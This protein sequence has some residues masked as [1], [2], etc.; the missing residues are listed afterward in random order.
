GGDALAARAGDDFVV[1]AFLGGHGV[2]DGFET[3]ELFFVHVLRGLLEAGEGADRRH[4]L[5]N[6]LHGTHLR[7]L[8][9]LIAEVFEREA[10]AE[11]GFLGELLLLFAVQRRFSLLDE[12]HHVAHAED[13]AYNAIGMEGLEGVGFFTCTDE[14]DGLAGHMPDG[15]RRAA[16]CV[17]VHFCQDNASQSKTRM[18]ILGR[19][20][21]VLAGHGIGDEQNLRR[22]EEFF[23][24]LHLRHE[25]FVDVQA[26]GGIDDKR[27]AA[28]DDGFT[29]GLFGQALD[30]GGVGGFALLVALV[31]FGFNG[32]GDDF[33]LL[34]GGGAIDVHRDQHGTV[35]TLLEPGGELAG[36]S[37][38]AAPLQA[39][40]EN[41]GGRLGG[42]FE[43]GRV[44]AEQ[45]DKLV[46]N[47]FDDLLGGGERGE[48]FGADGLDADLLDVVADDVEVVDGFEQG[49]GDFAE[50]FGDV[51]FSERALAAEGFKGA[52]EF[53]CK[54]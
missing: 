12:R 52:L 11:Q 48:D 44:F 34:T 15:E 51:F 17:A 46:A 30:E 7:D 35:T 21:G 33:K 20:D 2:D 50:G 32:F 5:E 40:H 26:A 39:G 18:K 8:T 36:G 37:G 38:F 29:A 31:E 49:Y 16:A 19:A 53:V 41:D 45:G 14:L 23:Q 6:R 10:I 9:N 43:A 54:V 47:D 24:A 4:H 42:E 1:A 27:I 13:A 3:N 22:V 28:H 25:L